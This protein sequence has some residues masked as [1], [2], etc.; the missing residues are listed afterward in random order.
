MVNHFTTIEETKLFIDEG[1]NLKKERYHNGILSS[2]MLHLA[3]ISNP[4]NPSPMLIANTDHCL[5]KYLIQGKIEIEIC[6]LVS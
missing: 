4:A 1:V 3:N 6:L 2:F 5:K